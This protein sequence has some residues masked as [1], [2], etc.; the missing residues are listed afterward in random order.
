MSKKSPTNNLLPT[1]LVVLT[2]G[3]VGCQNQA[4][5]TTFTQTTTE[6]NENLPQVVATT[7]VLCD[8]FDFSKC[9]P[10]ILQTKTGR[11]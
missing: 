7:S 1:I 3:F 5:R 2:I 11:S 4:A 8:M 10:P 9:K 6:V